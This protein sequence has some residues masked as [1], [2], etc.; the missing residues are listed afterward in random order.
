MTCDHAIEL[1]PWL[2]NGSL[3]A[4]ERDEVWHHLE[5]CERCRQ[6]LAETRETWSVFAQHLPSQD[7]VALAWGETPSEAVEE[8]LASCPSCAAELELAR[9]SRRLE[10][11]DNLAIFPA[12][13]PT[14]EAR[15]WRLAALAAGLTGLIAVSGWLYTAQ[16][17]SDLSARMAKREPRP[18]AIHAATAPGSLASQQR[19]AEMEAEL[20]GL[21]S[22]QKELEEQAK[23][24]GDRLAQMESAPRGLAEPQINS[25]VDDVNA[26]GDVVRGGSS[27]EKIVP[28]GRLATP[29]FQADPEDRTPERMVEIRDGAGQLVWRKEGLRRTEHD[30]YSLTFPAGF[31]KPGRYTIQLYGNENGKRVPRESYRIRVQ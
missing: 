6:T 1:L 4:G 10:Q 13:R 25:W 2:L 15:R 27:A 29:L 20:E 7:L 16:Q 5:T 24:A 8:H 23:K 19:L 11:A 30:D 9:M 22:S 28:Y 21:R 12:A 26:G 17:A 18:S 14:G 31:L 3:A